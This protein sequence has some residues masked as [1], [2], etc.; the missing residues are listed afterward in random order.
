MEVFMSQLL[1]RQLFN[2][3][4][5]VLSLIC[6][7][8]ISGCSGSGGS[9]IAFEQ[10]EKKVY[11]MGEINEPPREGT[12]I[13]GVFVNR[14]PYDGVSTDAPIFIAAD[15]LKSISE[16]MKQGISATYN[17]LNP[18]VL[19]LPNE[20]DVNTLLNMLG[21]ERD[22][23]M[24][25]GVTFLNMFAVDL[26]KGA[27]FRWIM[28]PT[29]VSDNDH[30]ASKIDNFAERIGQFREWL[31][32]NGSRITDKELQERQKAVN[33]LMSATKGNTGS[34]MEDYVHGYNTTVNITE[35]GGIFQLS[36][37]IYALH[38]FK[39]QTDWFYVRQ[40]A[41]LNME[42]AYSSQHTQWE[43]GFGY[44]TIGFYAG[45]YIMDNYIENTNLQKQIQTLRTSPDTTT[46]KTE[47]QTGMDWK[48]TGNVGFES[49][50]PTG[51]VGVEL[52]ITNKKT[53]NIQE[54]K[55]Y[56]KIGE[57]N[58]SSAKW[59]YQFN[60]V[61]VPTIWWAYVSFG[62]PSDLQIGTFSPQNHWLWNFN[63]DV[64]EDYKSQVFKSVFE[65]DFMETT[66]K[67]VISFWLSTWHHLHYPKTFINY[68]S[69]P[70]PPVLMADNYI[71]LTKSG[72]TVP[73]DLGVGRDWTASC[74]QSWCKVDPQSGDADRT[75]VYLTVDE[76]KTNA[77]RKANITFR[78][79]DLKGNA[80]TEV[81]QSQY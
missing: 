21:L 54:C 28:V 7:F 22:F 57:T 4:L 49:I 17:N 75:R 79:T 53:V 16:T 62:K 40:E 78:T 18:I 20:E 38:D 46:D 56:N 1:G 44:E 19:I 12:V 64:R 8:I 74:D 35:H 67:D 42:G 71:N 9:G 13:K 15:I 10:Y 77:N 26:E 33:A 58:Q 6:T 59:L 24:P 23:K 45:A 50:K 43:S 65:I 52:D 32:E 61:V 48:F 25:E 30:E 31:L 36:Y 2:L 39:T 70:Y 60:D 80:K 51:K 34:A 69:L 37:W 76:N 41:Q 14:I 27:S 11:I 72:Q 55:V 73:I 47:I 68:I 5:V 3:G 63:S 66:A 81:Y 29:R